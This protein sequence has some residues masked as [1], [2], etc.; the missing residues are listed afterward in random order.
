MPSKAELE[1]ARKRAAKLRDEI[2][3]HSH[4]Y[5]VEDRP[6]ISDAEYDRLYQE[7]VEIEQAHPELVTLDSPTQRVGG[8]PSE[9]FAPVR[10]HAR[11]YSL[12]NAF[13]IEELKAWADRVARGV[14]N[15][16]FACELKIDGVAVALTYE[17]GVYGRGATR[18]DGVTGEDVTANIRTIRGVPMKLRDP[19]PP[20][21]LEVR[22][23]VYYPKKGFT[24]LNEELAAAG[25]PTFANP[26]NAAA[27]SLRQKDPAITAARPLTYL[28]HGLGAVRGKRLPT[29]ADWLAALREAG[30]RTA[31]Q[32]TVAKDLDEVWA[33]IEHWHEH[34]HDIEYEID[35]VVV[36]VNELGA[37]EELGYTSHAPRWA[38]AYKYPPEEQVTK[39]KDI[40]IHI[41]RTGAATPYAVLDPVHVGG[42]T[43]STATLHNADEVERKDVRPGDFVVVR[44]AGD[45]IPEVLGPV[46]ERRRRGLKRW[47]MPT[48]CPACGSEI[49][50]E[51][52]EVVAYCTGIDCP[53]QRVE[54]I[55]H[56]AGRGALDIEGFGY[57]TIIELTER[58]LVK[59]IGDIYSLTDE[60]I[61][62]L[63]GF[64]DKKIQN[65]RRSIENSKTRPL[66]RLLAGL[67]IRHVGGTVANQ[68]AN[69]FSTLDAL[70]SA[71]EDEVNA[72]EGIGPVIAH[73]VYEF[74]RQPRNR[75]VLEKLKAAGLRT[76][77]ERKVVKETALTGKT[78]VITGGFSSMTREEAREALK[79]AGA[80]VTDTV[81]KKTD[82]VVV[83]DNPGSKLDKA[84]SLGVKTADEKELLRLLGR[85]A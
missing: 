73:S 21:L 46:L 11:M 15:V 51:E 25:N 18:G 39:L 37:Q 79:E 68:L 38:I 12:D 74:F 23:E 41:G 55:F 33:F 56:F 16:S 1:R 32:T 35:G 13:S 24:K 62:T 72:V 57:Q 59:D 63:E 48:R 43:V 42:V 50:R 14:S 4:L 53:M 8:A 30:L 71:T 65:L 54:R 64:K 7:L 81:S 5:H 85:D 44:R 45:V 69:H 22:G 6:Q 77:D 26:R 20:A 84:A 19:K 17:D 3:R 31:P 47:K 9:T 34:R 61:A 52:G 82:L 60:Q 75:A 40:Q 78:V 76:E 66:A 27:G 2:D 80:K 10:H 49:V 29:Q 36:K 70:E 83:G 28:I 67:G 58:G